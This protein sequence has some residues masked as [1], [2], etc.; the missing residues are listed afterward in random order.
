MVNYA[1]IQS[2]IDHGRGIAAKKLGP[3]FIAY[4]IGAAAA[5]DF[6]GAWTVVNPSFPLFRRRLKTESSI[7]SGM[8]K[9]TLFFDIVADMGP[10]LLGDVFYQND[11]AYVPGVS[12][13]A[14]AT[15]LPNSIQF[16]AMC[17]CWHGPVSKAIG[18]RLDRR[19]Q[20][21]RPNQTPKVQT[22]SGNK[23][24]W[25]STHENDRPLVLS[26]GQYQFGN[27]GQP[28]S[29]VPVGLA[30]Y[31][32]PTGEKFFAP[33]PPGMPKPQFWFVYIPPIPGYQP[34]EG[35]AIVT[36]DGVRYWIS[37]PYQ[38]QAGIVGSQL[39]VDREEAPV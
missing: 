8:S 26:G 36:E 16:E 24:Y 22:Q 2:K 11:P 12:Y 1:R 38:Q 39:V 13:G 25:A 18:A 10:F 30:A 31:Y 6:P 15:L 20:I 21:F 5:G 34:V 35:D 9:G 4:R 3:P 29:F 17:L 37:H 28:A 23:V 14:G 7:E 32:R 33:A 19:A 27:V